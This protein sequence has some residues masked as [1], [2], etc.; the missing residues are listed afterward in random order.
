M[1]TSRDGCC[2]RR[3]RRDCFFFFFRAHRRHDVLVV[4][5]GH[6]PPPPRH[7]LLCPPSR[8]ADNFRTPPPPVPASTPIPHPP[9]LKKQKQAL[10]FIYERRSFYARLY[11]IVAPAQRF[12]GPAGQG[13]ECALPR[14][15]SDVGEYLR[16][17]CR[18]SS[19]CQ[20][21]V[22]VA[23][24]TDRGGS[25]FFPAPNASSSSSSPQVG[26]C[27]DASM[28]EKMRARL[29]ARLIEA[30]G[31]VCS[32]LS[33][34]SKI[35]FGFVCRLIAVL[36]PSAARGR[37]SKYTTRRRKPTARVVVTLQ[38]STPSLKPRH[39]CIREARS[40]TLIRPC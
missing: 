20:L 19:F 10:L 28:D 2:C 5:L 22:T 32:L 27:R 25:N 11:E 23:R 14:P 21:V 6:S 38:N 7:P 3:E 17:R 8:L 40:F 26:E 31:R 13:G 15:G 39:L 35:G 34:K 9:T 33:D 29:A 1:A 37:R 4:V 24:L 16:H 30:V 36:F 12:P 18:L